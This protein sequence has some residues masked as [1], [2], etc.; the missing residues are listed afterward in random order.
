MRGVRLGDRLV[1]P[2]LNVI[3]TQD[4]RVHVE[5][6]VMEL[7]LEF[8]RHPGEVVSK[9]HIIQNVWGGAYVCEQVVPNAVSSLRRALGDSAKNPKF[10]ETIPKRGYR[11]IRTAISERGAQPLPE[12]FDD[13]NGAILRV[14]Y[15]RHEETSASLNPHGRIAKKSS[16]KSLIVLPHMPSW[17]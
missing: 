4:A 7:L 16:G 13:L 1:F 10:I 17:P 15:L 8:A 12:R 11:L 2:E 3:A 5:P 6:K 14:R 9:E